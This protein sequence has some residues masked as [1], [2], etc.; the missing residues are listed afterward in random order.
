MCLTAASLL[1]RCCM[2]FSIQSRLSCMMQN[3]QMAQRGRRVCVHIQASHLLVLLACVLLVPEPAE[4][5]PCRQRRA[6]NAA[7]ARDRHQRAPGLRQKHAGGTAGGAVPARWQHGSRCLH[8]RLLPHLSGVSHARAWTLTWLELLLE[9]LT[10]FSLSGSDSNAIRGTLTVRAARIGRISRSSLRSIQGTSCSRYEATQAPTTWHSAGAFACRGCL[11]LQ[12]VRSLRR[13]LHQHG[14]LL[15]SATLQALRSR[16]TDGTSFGIP[17]YDKSAHSGRGDRADADTWPQVR[18]FQM[19]V[20]HVRR[21]PCVCKVHWRSAIKA[22]VNL[23]S[24]AGARARG[25]RLVRGLDAG[26]QA[27]PDRR[28]GRSRPRP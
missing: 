28:R 19:T 5:A 4:A 24:C 15:R 16:H 25:P 7:A 26:V 14:V 9:K 21:Q 18:A 10:R 27:A 2:G 8:R 3:K 17:R 13:R 6:R 23:I 1:T 22:H 20:V 12:H 11:W